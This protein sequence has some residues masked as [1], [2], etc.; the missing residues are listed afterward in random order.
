MYTKFSDHIFWGHIE[1]HH[2]F[3]SASSENG[4]IFFLWFEIRED[5]IR[6]Y[7]S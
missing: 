3:C 1:S 2:F 7:N 4:N 5:G 6:W